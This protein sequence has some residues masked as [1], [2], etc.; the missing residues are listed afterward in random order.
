MTLETWLAFLVTE[1]VLC[2][3]PG[4]AVLYVVAHGVGQG[5]RAGLAANLGVLA[6]NA[7]YFALSAAGLGA[8]LLAS[9]TL[10]TILK[11]AGAAYLVWLGV[12]MWRR[13]AAGAVP[14]ADDASPRALGL[15]AF[16]VTALNPKGIAFFV[17]FVP[18]FVD[19]ARPLLPQVAIL[20]ATF[21]TLAGLNVLGYAL[22]AGRARRAVLRP[23]T[24]RLLNR[25]GAGALVGAGAIT[26]TMQRA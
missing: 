16:V 15:R 26:A 11:W 3:T 4:P 24:L 17:A 14:V 10:F 8:L 12:R 20:E 21:V 25:A 5:P 7:V 23:A 19:P 22:L 1:T 9:H 18:Q 13:S 6:G 2:L